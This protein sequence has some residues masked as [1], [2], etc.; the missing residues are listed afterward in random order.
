MSYLQD[1]LLHGTYR[2]KILLAQ[3]KSNDHCSFVSFSTKFLV[4]VQGIG[5]SER[6][7]AVEAIVQPLF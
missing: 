2:L 6:P 7:P 5:M 3:V 4:H 1:N